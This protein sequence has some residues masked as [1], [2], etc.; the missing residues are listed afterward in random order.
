M[1]FPQG[2]N[3]HSLLDEQQDPGRSYHAHGGYVWIPRYVRPPTQHHTY[4][5]EASSD[6]P[7]S[8]AQYVR[9]LKQW[10]LEKNSTKDKWEFAAG[11]VQKRRLEGKETEVIINGRPVPAKK[12]KKEMARYAGCESS[13]ERVLGKS[14][15]TTY[16]FMIFCWPFYNWNSS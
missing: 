15:Y 7:N 9:K 13:S 11:Q 3:I 12:L 6:A 8:K 16:H 14:Y 10:R 2:Y 5:S 1:G 4:G